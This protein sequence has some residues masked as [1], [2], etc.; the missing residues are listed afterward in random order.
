MGSGGPKKQWSIRQEN[1]R[2]HVPESVS[3]CGQRVGV[4]T[5]REAVTGGFPADPG[6][7]ISLWATESGLGTTLKSK[8]AALIPVPATSDLEL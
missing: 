3:A 5:E 8:A 7:I 2:S 4:W 6:Q 1:Q